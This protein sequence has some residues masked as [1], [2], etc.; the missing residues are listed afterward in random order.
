ADWLGV[1][2]ASGPRIVT[3]ARAAAIVA[4]AGGRAVLGVFGAQSVPVIREICGAARLAGAQL[5][6]TYTPADAAAL[7]EAG[8]LVWRVVRLASDADLAQLDEPWDVD[9]VLV[10]PRVPQLDGGAGRP[11][12]LPLARA[13]RIRLGAGRM[14]LA[15]GLAPD[16]VAAAVGLVAPDVVDVSSGVETLPGIKDHRRIARFVEAA[17]GRSAV[18]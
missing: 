1:V 2:F 16:T 17:R 3:P 14:V 9:A 5:H 13:A 10:E 6:G 12:G 8:L 7:R 11:L 4:A 18:T 15:G